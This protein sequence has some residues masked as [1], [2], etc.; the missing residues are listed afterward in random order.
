MNRHEDH[1]LRRSEVANDEQTCDGDR[2]D[3]AESGLID[4]M[5]GIA[6]E[7]VNGNAESVDV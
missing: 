6:A 2:L 7:K 4:K 5:S 1:E 3:S